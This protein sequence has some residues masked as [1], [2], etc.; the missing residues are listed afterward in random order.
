[1]RNKVTGLQLLR[2]AT[3]RHMSFLIKPSLTTKTQTRHIHIS[4]TLYHVDLLGTGSKDGVGRCGWQHLSK[5]GNYREMT[6]SVNRHHFT[7]NPD[8]VIKKKTTPF[9]SRT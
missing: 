6:H 2:G 9:L 4:R 8:F 3:P 1:M 5:T 7:E